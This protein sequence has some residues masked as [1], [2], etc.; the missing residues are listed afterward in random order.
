MGATYLKDASVNE[1][2][3]VVDQ[4]L[5]EFCGFLGIEIQFFRQA[6]K[7]KTKLLTEFKD[8]GSKFVKLISDRNNCITYQRLRIGVYRCLGYLNSCRVR[9]IILVRRISLV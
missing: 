4:V 6:E 9:D 8:D 2:E 5:K 3:I 1:N 7:L